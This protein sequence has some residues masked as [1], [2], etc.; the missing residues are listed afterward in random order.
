[1][2]PLTLLTGRSPVAILS[3]M[4]YRA[5]CT[6]LLLA[7]SLPAQTTPAKTAPPKTVVFLCEHGA[8]KSVIAAA[9]FNKLAAE[10]HLPFQAIARGTTPQE[11][12]SKSAVEG[13]RKDGLTVPEEKP[14]LLSPADTKRAVRVVAFCPV[15]DS[16]AKTKPVDRFDVPAPSDGYDKSRDEIL[17][18]V[19]DLIDQLAATK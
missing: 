7:A 9:Y 11:D 2:T 16:V 5:F 6:L 4:K 17:K 10:R 12:L 1:V 15:P 13:L 18:H 8:A 3:D 14:R 19:R